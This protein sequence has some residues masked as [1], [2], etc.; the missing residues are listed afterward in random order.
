[1]SFIGTGIAIGNIAGA[2]SASLGSALGIGALG[3][4]A[5]GA[6][7]LGSLTAA[8]A[9]AGTAGT[10][11]GALA[12]TGG[13]AAGTGGAAA[14][15]VATAA[16]TIA[17]SSTGG[18]MPGSV[19][20]AMGG[21]G[22]IPAGAV[23]AS[24]GSGI[25]PG[26][27]SAA[28]TAVAPGG[29]LAVPAAG[30]TMTSGG[31]TGFGKLGDLAASNIT[32]KG[33]EAVTNPQP[34]YDSSGQKEID[35]QKLEGQQFASDVYSPSSSWQNPSWMQGNAQGGEIRYAAKQGGSVRLRNGDFIVPA[36]VVSAIG[37]GSTKAGAKYLDHLF[38][39]LTAGPAPKAGSLAKRR[40]QERRR[41]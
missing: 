27:I 28:P 26:I 15:P 21:P 25:A 18:I 23:P 36:D 14:A 13:A 32:S 19:I 38:N 30:P 7:G 5:V 20:S 31:I 37:N 17:T 16:P 9:L 24:S 2:L 8:S 3:S 41:A 10:G 22:A 6:G 12:G 29:S 11:L 33:V 1:M 39:A 4:T 40:A 34:V 35:R